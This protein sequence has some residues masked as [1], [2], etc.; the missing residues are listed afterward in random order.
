MPIDGIEELVGL[1]INTLPLVVEHKTN[2]AI[3][4]L[5]KELQDNINEINIRSNINLA[6]LQSKRGRLFDSLFVYE[7]YPVQSNKIQEA[8]LRIIF[9]EGI[10]K[11][12]YPLVVTVCETI[13][14]INFS[15]KYAGE[16]L[17][18][19]LFKEEILSIV[20]GLMAQIVN[21]LKQSPID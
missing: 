14:E 17:A 6:K 5:I 13:G 16:L 2:K 9:K 3:V 7:N 12:D 11:L 21:N 1:Y 19:M 8:R 4:E 10:E 18:K 20:E 15:I